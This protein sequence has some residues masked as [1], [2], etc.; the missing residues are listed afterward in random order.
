MAEKHQNER[1]LQAT[2]GQARALYGEVMEERTG[3]PAAARRAAPLAA[4]IAGW[5]RGR[6]EVDRV[7]DEVV[8][9]LAG[10]RPSRKTTRDRRE[11]EWGR[12]SIAPDHG[13]R[14]GASSAKNF[15]P[16]GRP[17]RAA[18]TAARALRGDIQ[19]Y[20]YGKGKK[21]MCRR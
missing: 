9:W 19:E 5:R 7:V 18:Q 3:D 11:A 12:S 15:E 1:R 6:N 20:R 8:P 13:S 17:D 21:S 4:R 2:G 16:R 10:K 14:C